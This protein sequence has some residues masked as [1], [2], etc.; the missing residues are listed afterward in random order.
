MWV[1]ISQ[2]HSNNTNTGEGLC[3]PWWNSPFHR[4]FLALENVSPTGKIIIIYFKTSNVFTFWELSR[5]TIGQ[6]RTKNDQMAWPQS[7]RANSAA[8]PETWYVAV[9]QT[10]V[11]AHTWHRISS[12][13]CFHSHGQQVY[14]TISGASLLSKSFA[15]KGFLIQKFAKDFTSKLIRR[16]YSSTC[17]SSPTTHLKF[18]LFFFNV[19]PLICRTRQ[20]TECMERQMWTYDLKGFKRVWSF[21][22]G[23]VLF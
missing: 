11:L 6:H 12:R 16:M 5:P 20:H 1:N 13:I 18:Y 23:S 17:T 4:R 14:R 3:K 2:V 9:A 22:D 10:P 19:F 21:F 8:S 7:R 15:T